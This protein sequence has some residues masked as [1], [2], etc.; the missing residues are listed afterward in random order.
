[1]KAAIFGATGKIG[2]E[3]VPYI[4][5]NDPDVEIVA[6]GHRKE[7][8]FRNLDR[9][10]YYS[11]NIIDQADFEKLPD[12]V[13]AVINLAAAV[14]TAVNSG[15]VMAY[16]QLN[17][18]G[19]VNILDYALKAGADRIIYSQTYN[20]VFGAPD[21]EVIIHP[22]TPRKTRYKGEAAVYAITKNTAVD[23]Q[24]YYQEKYG[25]KSF[26]LRLPTVQCPTRSP[27]Y[28]IGGEKR[29]RPFR[30]MIQ[31]ACNGEPIEIWGDP[32]HIMDMVYVDDCCQMF[33]LALKANVN[34]GV[35]NVGTGI[36]TT[37]QQQVEGMI[38]VFSPEGHKSEIR[39]L[40]DKPNGKPFIMD[41]ENARRDLGYE[42]KYGY[43]DM[44]KEFK[45]RLF[46]ENKN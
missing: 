46:T 31:Q 36:G 9:V 35:Y 18:I 39:Y 42:P 12:Q 41:I 45:R 28:L 34:G 5:K 1:M 8:I 2:Q 3:L 30:K 23:L 13:D 7:N 29:L 37:L 14:T 21:A 40:P 4:V 15:E 11:V 44:L 19:A 16:I 38:E 33:Y 22:E 27:Y 17:I 24:N 6:V 10:T 26:V 32:N 20:D 25:I 43:I